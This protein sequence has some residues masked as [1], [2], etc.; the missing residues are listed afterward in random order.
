MDVTELF[1]FS[2]EWVV[3]TNKRKTEKCLRPKFRI[4]LKSLKTSSLKSAEG[5]PISGS[6]KRYFDYHIDDPHVAEQAFLFRKKLFDMNKCL[7]FFL[8]K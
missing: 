7:D 8:V 2:F 3:R 6:D 4:R 5:M 1:K